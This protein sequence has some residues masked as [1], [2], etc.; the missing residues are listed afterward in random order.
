ML[1]RLLG[2]LAPLEQNTIC[3]TEVQVIGTVAFL[4]PPLV[5]PGIRF[6]ST[7]PHLWLCSTCFLN[8]PEK[9]VLNP[10]VHLNGCVIRYVSHHKNK[11][12]SIVV[13]TRYSR[14]NINIFPY[15]T[16]MPLIH[17]SGKNLI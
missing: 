6:S 15:Y 4:P 2:S 5:S 14:M 1:D 10:Q 11:N 12:E 17:K 3:G 13:T 7:Q 8:L 9:R 16:E